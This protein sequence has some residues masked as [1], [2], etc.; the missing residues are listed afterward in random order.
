MLT[1]VRNGA[2][3]RLWLGSTTSGFATWGLPF[4]LGYAMTQDML[5]TAQLGIALAFRT[6]GFLVGVLLGGIF[7]DR[8][9]CRG[10]VL[11]ASLIAAVGIVLTLLSLP[12]DTKHGSSISLLIAGAM[13]SGFGQG[14]CRPAFQALVPKVIEPEQLQ[15][16]NAAMSLSIRVVTL[17]GPAAVT[18]LAIWQGLHSGFALLI[19]G[20]LVSAFVPPWVAEQKRH[21]ESDS[22]HVSSMWF[23]MREA[24][25]EA[26]RHPWFIVSLV[27]LT[28]VIAAGYS[29]TSVLLPTISKA[30]FGDS[31]LLTYS[32][33][34]YALGGLTG[35]VLLG[36]F[37]FHPQGWWALIGLAVYGVV[38]LSLLFDHS[39]LLPV[40]AYFVAGVGIEIFNVIWFSSLQKEIPKDKL[41]RISSIDFLCSYGFAPLGLLAIAPLTGWFGNTAVLLGCGAVCLVAP[42]IAMKQKSTKYFKVE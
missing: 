29:A 20:W 10:V 33:T 31:S 41:A 26:K 15:P 16:A 14:A 4:L 35:A 9:S 23:D 11:I 12:I 3:V 38:P 37:T 30:N 1:I 19:F 36:R 32:M 21:R 24:L 25:E 17:A 5:T 13:L 8:Y 2:F 22:L 39:V 7:A 34:A 27:A 18:A 40:V 42:L 6:G 28:I